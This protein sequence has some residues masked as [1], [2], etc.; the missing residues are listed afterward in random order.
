MEESKRKLKELEEWINAHDEPVDRVCVADIFGDLKSEIEYWMSMYDGQSEECEDL[1]KLKDKEIEQLQG[2]LDGLKRV[3][4]RLLKA[5]GTLYDENFKMEKTL[6][7]IA[8]IEDNMD[9]FLRA[10][11]T[12]ES[13]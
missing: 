1:M 2:Q 13:L 4:D 10:K 5:N 11:N 3:N 8:S 9:N 12:L 7:G 6:K